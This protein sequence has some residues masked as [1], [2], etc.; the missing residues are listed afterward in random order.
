MSSQQPPTKK[1]KQVENKQGT[2]LSWV[3]P[4]TSDTE[5]GVVKETIRIKEQPESNCL[6]IFREWYPKQVLYFVKVNTNG[7]LETRTKGI[8]DKCSDLTCTKKYALS[9]L[10]AC[11][12]S[13]WTYFNACSWSLAMSDLL[14]SESFRT[15][16]STTQRSQLKKNWTCSQAS[17]RVVTIF[18]LLRLMISP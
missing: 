13:S 16:S 6:Q 8:V 17:K 5:P 12:H 4:C 10:R 18:I 7:K 9:L 3:K 1:S 14:F 2:L 15:W 11:Y